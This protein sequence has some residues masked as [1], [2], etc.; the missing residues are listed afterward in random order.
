M[1]SAEALLLVSSAV[2]ALRFAR[3]GDLGSII[4]RVEYFIASI[5]AEKVIFFSFIP[6][7][8]PKGDGGGL[9]IPGLPRGHSPREALR[10]QRGAHPPD[11]LELISSR[12]SP[13][14]TQTKA[15]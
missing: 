8:P 1:W 9:I 3:K 7:N 4:K 10:A 11:H 2:C 12:S 15:D 6:L 13:N 5:I 14:E